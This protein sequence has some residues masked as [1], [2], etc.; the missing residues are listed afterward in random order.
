MCAC[1]SCFFTKWPSTE[2]WHTLYSIFTYVILYTVNAT[3]KVSNQNKYIAIMQSPSLLFNSW[4]QFTKL[5]HLT[6]LQQFTAYMIDCSDLIAWVCVVLLVLRSC[7]MACSLL[8]FAV[9]ALGLWGSRTFWMTWFLC[10]MTSAQTLRPSWLLFSSFDPVWIDA[11][12]FVFFC[13]CLW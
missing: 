12:H 10:V 8:L 2:S 4:W 7:L 3:F 13:G 9:L 11:Q 1:V 5:H 6:K